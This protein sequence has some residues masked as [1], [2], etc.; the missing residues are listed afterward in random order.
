[1]TSNTSNAFARKSLRAIQMTVLS[2]VL[3]TLAQAAPQSKQSAGAANPPT[4]SF[5]TPQQAADALIQAAATFD[6]PALTKI[7]GRDGEDLVSTEDTV[8]DKNRATAFAAKAREKRTVV[9]DPKNPRRAILS[10]GGEDW[11]VPIPIV[12]TNG[13]WFFDT[14]S[15]RQE[16]LFRRIGED[17]LTAI[18]VCRGFVE[19]QKDYAEQVHDNSGVNQ[20]AQRIISTPGKQDGLAWQNPDG[21]WGGP[22]GE[23]VAKALQEGYGEKGKPFYGYFFKVLTGQGPNAT[24]GQLD[25]VIHGAMI[26]GFALI[27]VPADYRVT[28]VNT[29]MVSYDGV[30]YQKD[31]G[32]DSVNIVKTIERYNPDKTW[33][34]TDDSR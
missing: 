33:R 18:N 7:L 15:G 8:A 9:I 10:I 5:A 11:P 31:L 17:E 27:A 34:P 2:W 21:S 16:I 25:Y 6:V 13:K 14:K 28:G 29:F 22:V 24:H 30:V 12:Q 32:P 3:A 23:R 26:G 1:M 19:A 4:V 20:Y